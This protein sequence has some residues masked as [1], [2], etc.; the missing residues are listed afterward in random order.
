MYTYLLGFQYNAN[1]RSFAFSKPITLDH[2]FS[3][4]DIEPQQDIVANEKNNGHQVWLMFISEI[5][6]KSNPE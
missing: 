6:P 5:A 2:P 3:V 4:D 1:Q